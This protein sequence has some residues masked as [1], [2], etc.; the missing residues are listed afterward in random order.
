MRVVFLTLYPDAAASPRYRVGQFLPYLRRQGVECTVS[1]PMEEAEWRRLT[2]PERQ[3]RPFWY[4]LHETPRRIEQ[5]LSAGW[6]DVVFVQKALMSAYLRGMPGLLKRRARRIVYDLDDAVHLAPPHPL[7]GVWK[8]LEDRAQ[9]AALMKLSDRILAGNAW[10][11]DE[12]RKHNEHVELFPTVVDTDRFVPPPK[13]PEAFRVG[14]IGSPSTTPTL[15]PLH[16][17]LT[18]VPDAHVV[19]V[20]ADTRKAAW[21]HVIVEPWDFDTEVEEVQQFSVGLL[22]QMRD[23]WT[24]GKCA[25]KALLYMACGVP[26]IATPYG[27]VLDIIQH[28]HNGLFA[29]QTEEWRAAIDRL[30]DPV[31]RK[32]LGE[33][34]RATVEERYSLRVA[35]PRM[36]EIL[37]SLE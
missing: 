33:A 24:R 29:E 3:G 37:R 6:H 7:R 36:L 9:I 25:L 11:A 27:A 17:T 30:R 13:A 5:I 28:E 34:A 22:P 21:G 14:W 20:G 26:C 32:Q 12:A 19:L 2:G 8:L 15:F 35:A 18:H 4:H 1:A 16:D 31:Y 10:L 23:E